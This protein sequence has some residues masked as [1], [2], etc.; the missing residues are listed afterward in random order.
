MESLSR[1]TR[2]YQ[3]AEKYV[4][5]IIY[6]THCVSLGRGGEGKHSRITFTTLYPNGDLILGTEKYHVNPIE[7]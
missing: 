3:F 7:T 6:F 1:R 2:E 5:I 4:I